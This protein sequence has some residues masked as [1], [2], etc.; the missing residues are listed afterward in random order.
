MEL[1][2][3]MIQAAILANPTYAEAYNNLGESHR[4]GAEG[5]RQATNFIVL[6]GWVT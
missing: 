4:A 3:K 6:S 5:S 1:A 2:L